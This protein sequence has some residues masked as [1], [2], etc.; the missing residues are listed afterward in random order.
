MVATVP[1]YDIPVILD[2]AH[3]R[4]LL[5]AEPIIFHCHHYNTFLQRSIKDAI[6]IDST[7]FLVGAAA[8]VAESQLR[9][10]FGEIPN[11][12]DR[13]RLAERIYCW[14]GFG[15]VDL[16]GLTEDGGVVEA[17]SSHYVSSW[18][19]K[20][21]TPIGPVDLFTQGWLGGAT[22]A[23]YDAP[24]GSFDVRQVS[25]GGTASAG[26]R[27]DVV[28]D[29]ASHSVWSSVGPGSLTDHGPGETGPAAVDYEGIYNAV[30]SLPLVGDQ[31]GLI[32]AF[33]VYLTHHYANYYNRIS[34]EFERAMEDR[35]GEDGIAAA[36]PL[37]VEAGHVC[38]FNTF[39]GIMQ[40]AEW[41]ALIRPTLKTP[42]DWVHGIVAVVNALGWGRWAVADVAESGATFTLHDDYESVGHLAMYGEADHAISYLAEGAAMGIMNLVYRGDIAKGPGL[43]TDFYDHLFRSSSSYQ[44]RF[45]ASQASGDNETVL[46]VSAPR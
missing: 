7:P 16:S 4:H 30:V 45:E 13:S 25:D 26:I 18:Q 20:F 2:H 12:S 42:E 15:R 29:Q 34:F 40:S 24:A 19:S 14:A 1:T 5:G 32:P 39:G 23:I 10:L 17:P 3:R 11:V 41:D 38:A 22:A 28:R 46:R 6:Y 31:L 27:Y 21:G 43:T 8:E 37:L 36:N 33:G 35:F 44:A 9:N